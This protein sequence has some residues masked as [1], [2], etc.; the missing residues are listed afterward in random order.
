MLRALCL[1]ALALLAAGCTKPAESTA[2]PYQLSLD[3][4]AGI[5]VPALV[6][7]GT[8][9]H[10]GLQTIAA[11]LARTLPTARLLPLTGSG[12]MTYVDRPDE[13]AAAVRD[14]AQQLGVLSAPPIAHIG[15]PAAT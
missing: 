1:L 12:H 14:F 3:Q 15:V 8:A 5:H 11:G 10:P 6:I 9:S 4:V 7:A 13:F 2:P